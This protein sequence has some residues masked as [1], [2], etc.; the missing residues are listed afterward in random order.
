MGVK[1][2]PKNSQK[3]EEQQKEE[4]QQKEEEREN[5]PARDRIVSLILFKLL[6]K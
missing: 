3:E 5:R 6:D 2:N 4:D 1:E